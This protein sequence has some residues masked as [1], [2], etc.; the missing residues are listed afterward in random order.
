M[1]DQTFL[2]FIEHSRRQQLKDFLNSQLM[3]NESTVDA[4]A[5]DAVATAGGNTTPVFKNFID[6]LGKYLGGFASIP[7]KVWG[8]ISSLF[9]GAKGDDITKDWINSR[10]TDEE[11]ADILKRA[12]S[13]GF[14]GKIE[15]ILA[16][17]F[18]FNKELKKWVAGR[19]I[20]IP[21]DVYV[22][23]LVNFTKSS[24]IVPNDAKFGQGDGYAAR[25]RLGQKRDRAEEERINAD[26]F[27]K[28][29]AQMDDPS[30]M[31]P[32]APTPEE[33]R[34]VLKAADIIVRAAPETEPAVRQ[35]LAEVL[36][37]GGKEHYDKMAGFDRRTK[38]GRE[39]T[40]G[41]LQNL[42]Y[43]YGDLQGAMGD[44]DVKKGMK[45]ARDRWKR[46]EA[47]RLRKDAEAAST[48]IGGPPAEPA[49][50]PV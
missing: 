11:A 18:M 6:T 10:P 3:M 34:A 32:P 45:N 40:T 17:I 30:S 38:A 47:R 26:F 4:L 24:N 29:Q 1:K 7:S 21:R 25:P 19:D 16:A 2:N 15:D 46:R 48:N 28:L 20:N 37:G 31:K 9:A 35:T 49:T 14:K 12:S 41:V 23:Q 27:A 43:E 33:R 50:Q 44:P 13:Y 39:G 36:K 42:G 5:Q 22:K 8:A